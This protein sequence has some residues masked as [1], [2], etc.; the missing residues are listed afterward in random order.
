MELDRLNI[1]LAQYQLGHVLAEAKS[2]LG[3]FQ[4]QHWRVTVGAQETLI[5]K[6]QPMVYHGYIL[7]TYLEFTETVA[8]QFQQAGLPVH[9]ALRGQ[10]GFTAVYD[11]ECY[12]VSKWIPGQ[13]IEA[14]ELTES[15]LYKI[16]QMVGRLHTTAI[17]SGAVI[18][19]PLWEDI[20]GPR[21][22]REWQSLFRRAY[23]Q[24]KTIPILSH[25]DL[26][27]HN[28]L[29]NDD[30]LTLID[31][32]NAGLID[33]G[34]ELYGVLINCMRSLDE[35]PDQDRVVAVLQG[36]REVAGSIP[37]MDET[38]AAACATS[39]MAWLGY[40]A[41]RQHTTELPDHQDQI[42]QEEV[43]SYK[44]LAFILHHRDSLAKIIKKY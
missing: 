18:E 15:Q 19:T 32:E 24:A 5:K 33:P 41:E 7:P 38:H 42:R 40:L 21:F 17:E 39:W 14:P 30:E 35:K 34:L 23:A 10:T 2:F 6:I 12:L 29:W 1:L 27:L 36:Y 37:L 8:E 11:D 16:G 31:W 25:R 4:H 26:N 43:Y 44:A 20:L 28:F 22:E 3:G 9:H 13:V